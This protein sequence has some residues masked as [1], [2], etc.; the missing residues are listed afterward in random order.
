VILILI[1]WFKV[2]PAWFKVGSRWVQGKIDHL[3][4][5]QKQWW[6]GFAVFGSWWFYVKPLFF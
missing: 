6:C 1:L 2:V 4:P 5:F 3:E